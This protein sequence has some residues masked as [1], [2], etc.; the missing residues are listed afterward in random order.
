MVRQAHHKWFDEHLQ[1]V[2]TTNQTYMVAAKLAFW[3]GMDFSLC[4]NC[5]FFRES[6]LDDMEKRDCFDCR[7]AFRPK[8]NF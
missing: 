1:L 5:T 6:V 4:F 2:L 3:S 7:L 8:L